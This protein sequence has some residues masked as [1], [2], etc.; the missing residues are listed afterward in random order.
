MP[1]L[2]RS[3]T[4]TVRHEMRW[5]FYFMP[6]SVAHR[7]RNSGDER[8]F[9]YE[10]IPVSDPDR[11]WN[12]S[13][14]QFHL[15]PRLCRNSLPGPATRPGGALCVPRGGRQCSFLDRERGCSAGGDHWCPVV[16]TP[17]TQVRPQGFV[18]RAGIHVRAERTKSRAGEN[19]SESACART[20]ARQRPAHTQTDD[21]A[22]VDIAAAEPYT[23]GSPPAPLVPGSIAASVGA[24][25]VTSPADRRSTDDRRPGGR[26]HD[27]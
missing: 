11:R 14:H 16:R 18:R 9:H 5:S 13:D 23:P 12:S 21:S 24:G 2:T 20:K 15:Q 19:G 3:C 26:R 8:N 17:Q 1:S 6:C 7:L 4:I 22:L 25:T 27:R 10:I